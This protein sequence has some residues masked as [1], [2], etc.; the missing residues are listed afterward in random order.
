MLSEGYNSICVCQC[1]H[2]TTEQRHVHVRVHLWPQY[3]AHSRIIM[4]YSIP[5]LTE[6]KKVI[7]ETSFFPGF[8]LYMIDHMRNSNHSG[9]ISF[10][11]RVLIK[12]EEVVLVH[13]CQHILI[14][15]V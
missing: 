15:M 7:R 11:I 13:K 5:E 1:A 9:R 12:S 3:C 4:L 10:Y 8:L 2:A 14:A 6:G